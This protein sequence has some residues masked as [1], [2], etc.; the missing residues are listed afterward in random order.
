MSDAVLV[1]NAGSS[2]LKF[3]E[4]AVRRDGGLELEVNG[5]IEE[6]YGP[7]RFRARDVQ[8]NV[9][10]ERTWEA[11]DAPQHAGALEFL[12][13]WF[14]QHAGSTRLMAVGH[15]V[16]HGGSVYAAPVRADAAVLAELAAFV[17]L[18]P[19][20]QPHNLLPIRILAERRPQL[21][22]VACFDTAFHRTAPPLAQAFALPARV[23]ERGVRRYGFHGLS[24]EY[25]ASVLPQHDPRAAAGRTVVLHLGNGASMCAMHGGK[26]IAST[27]GFTAVDGLPM[28]TRSGN[29]DPGVVLYC[30]QALQMDAAAIESLLYKESGLLGVSG[31]SSDMRELLASEDP[32]A[33]F[34]IDLF[35]YRIGRELGSLAAALGGLDAIVFTAGIG[36]RAAAVRAGV[37]GQAAWLG[38]ELDAEANAERGARRISTA[39]SRVSAW[40]I[41]TDEELMIARHTL[42]LVSSQ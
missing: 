30:L 7:A 8:G 33:R 24:Y 22:Q 38:V 23:T 25:I 6:L 31:L 28:G 14:A 34:A 13:D 5:V 4:F 42:R 16:V 2:S 39:E 26:S 37:C 21:P 19:L 40:V 12:F 15:R 1:L 18:A 11:Q 10:G 9:L 3:S 20:H 36:E 41:P 35:V 27:M 17:P 29:L 32:Q